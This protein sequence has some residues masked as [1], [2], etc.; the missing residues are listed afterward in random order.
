MEAKA[1]EEESPLSYRLRLGCTACANWVTASGRLEEIAPLV[2]RSLWSNEARHELERLPPYIES[3]VRQEVESHAAQEGR[4]LITVA[5]FQEARLRG[6]VSWSSAAKDRLANVPAPI[7]SMAKV[8][9]ER[10]AVEQGLSEVTEALMDEAKAK[11][12]GMRGRQ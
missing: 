10:M 2:E 6:K 8:E 3:L 7:R 11:F 12:L 9:I 1:L 5:L 4:F